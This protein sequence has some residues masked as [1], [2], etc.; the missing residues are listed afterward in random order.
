MPAEETLRRHRR[1]TERWSSPAAR[2]GPW[3]AIG[4]LAIGAL[5]LGIVGFA[6]LAAATRE[7]RS[8][9]DL[10]YLAL[11]LFVL[12][13]GAVRAP[14]PWEL[15]VARFLAPGVAAYTAVKALGLLFRER[16]EG[17]RARRSRKHVVV[18]G[19]GRKGWL[20]VRSLR[21]R[22]HRVVVIEKDAENDRIAPCRAE[23]ARVVVGDARSSRCLRN[24]GVSRA[25]HLVAISEDDGANA[26]IAVQGRS[27]ASERRGADLSCFAHV[28][29][30]GLCALLR[31]QEL[32]RPASQ[33]FRLDFF[34]VF[35]R[36]ARQVL[37]EFPVWGRTSAEDREAAHMVV[38]GVGRFGGTLIAAAARG[39]QATY[40]RER[41][42]LRATLLDRA[43]DS[44]ADALRLR[45]PHLGE[46]C[47]LRPR[48]M[49]FDSPEFQRGEFLFDAQGE[50]DVTSTY[51]CV[52]DDSDALAAA[53]AL[54]R[55]LK[56]DR[57]PIVVRMTQ[58]GGLASLLRTREGADQEFETLH[59][60]ALLERTC[61]AGLLEE[62][63]NEI[64]ARVIHQDYVEQQAEKGA[65]PDTN[66]SMV[67][68]EALTEGLKQS[69]REQAAHIGVKLRAAGCDL[70]P[71]TDLDAESFAFESA[72][73][74]RLAEMEH[75]R[76]VEERRREGWKRGPQ[77][78]VGRKISPFLVPWGELA[79]STKDSDREF[80]HGLPRFLARAGF[81]IV[82]LKRTGARQALEN[83]GQPA[84]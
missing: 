61:H 77:K 47:E 1:G 74:E 8:A 52:D 68:W 80:V 62:S 64:L 78:D 14:V 13:S 10:F 11:Q 39:W 65:T 76:W 81:Q 36:G 44:K 7:P 22:R 30:P 23:G 2:A 70:A 25:R 42:P 19:L 31:T 16:I 63:T 12:E 48:P 67:A 84:G 28:M 69:N 71:L 53:L 32:E 34:N 59:A 60:F 9:L 55:H 58:A 38:V 21:E 17:F 33:A 82:R 29:D 3:V 49:E 75:A 35:E 5:A 56:E 18:C 40:G 57:I 45:Y 46:I 20:L 72:E 4:A 24:A 83:L 15:E 26:E 73:V 54:H 41:G 27:L 79:E 51:V 66:P 50:A 6:K 43:A 37:A